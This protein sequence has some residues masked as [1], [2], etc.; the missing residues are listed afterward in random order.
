MPSAHAAV[1]HE[2]L[3]RY[4]D[5]WLPAAVPGHRRVTY[6]DTGDGESAAAAARV[7][8]EFPDLL[9]RHPLTMA[10][11]RS[12][13]AV[14]AGITVVP[15]TDLSTVDPVFGFLSRLDGFPVRPG[16]EVLLSLDPAKA[17]A[18]VRSLRKAGLT[19]VSRVEL[20]DADGTAQAL[21]FGT[22][23]EKSLETFKNDLWALDEYAGIRYRDPID[24]EH[25][26]LDISL[27]P[28]L[29]PLRRCLVAH[30][31]SGPATLAELR[32]WTL[33]ETI[34]R[35]ED[36][37]R[38]VQAL[39]AAHEVTRTPAGGRLSPATVISAA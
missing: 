28:N 9:A 23:S 27:Q 19:Q 13:V 11:A 35:S 34:Y 12:D 10:L 22:A 30:L 29:R 24:A 16:V 5:A 6:V 15:A 39:V 2:L 36:A 33:H 26:L 38:A 25:T 14:P 32:A 21:V 8:A 4:L 37:T 17:A 20:V 1:T 31:R 3:V 7:F 18:A